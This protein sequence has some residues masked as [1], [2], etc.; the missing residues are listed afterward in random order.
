[1]SKL[2]P[3]DSL[4]KMDEIHTGFMKVVEYALRECGGLFWPVLYGFLYYFARPC[5]SIVGQVIFFAFGVPLIAISLL[6]PF[7]WKQVNKKRQED[8]A[9]RNEGQKKDFLNIRRFFANFID[10][11]NR[12]GNWLQTRLT[13]PRTPIGKSYKELRD[14]IEGFLKGYFSS[15]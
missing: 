3:W 6:Y 7:A 15:N 12:D 11:V 5:L 14:S 10:S 13:D 2:E 9:K 1:M 4:F 8:L